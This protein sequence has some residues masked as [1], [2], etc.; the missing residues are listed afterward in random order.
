[1][2]RLSRIKSGF[3]LFGMCVM[4]QGPVAA[5]TGVQGVQ[6]KYQN[7]G[8][9]FSILVPEDWDAQMDSNGFE[10]FAE[11][12]EKIKPSDSNPVVADPNLTV[13]VSRNPMP[14]DQ[15]SLETYAAQMQ[16]G[17]VKSLGESAGLEVFLKKTVDLP[18]KRTGLLYY[19]R[20]KKGSF[21]V[22]NA[23]LVVS[24]D[25]HLFRVTLTDYEVGFDANLE[26]VFP[27]MASID[28]GPGK[29]E[30]ESLLEV[31][32]PWLAAGVAVFLLAAGL[33]MIRH[34][35][36]QEKLSGSLE[37]SIHEQKTSRVPFMKPVFFKSSQN[38]EDYDPEFR[39]TSNQS[40]YN[41]A[42]GDFSEVPLSA[43]IGSGSLTP[44]SGTGSVTDPETEVS[45]ISSRY[46][47]AEVSKAGISS[48]T[49]DVPGS[50]APPRSR[51]VQSQAQ[52]QEALVRKAPP[53]PPEVRQTSTAPKS[54]PRPP[55]PPP[56]A[57][58]QS[59]VPE[60][61]SRPADEPESKVRLS[62]R[63]KTSAVPPP[64][65]AEGS[66]A[67][68]SAVPKPSEAAASSA[69]KSSAFGMDF[70]SVSETD[71]SDDV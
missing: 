53:P 43:A 47:N 37:E 66:R 49:F 31:L 25:T 12:K 28:V 44:R 59:R 50:S 45:G 61:P 57:P 41:E 19:L 68:K 29:V 46:E 69:P 62:E 6:L 36:S 60:A 8:L 34:R 30:R 1:M 4:A 27:F 14:I 54:A 38:E 33:H 64:P 65:A 52:G 48:G 9:S 3:L 15:E 55:V 10:V 16:T 17:L 7:E 70:T 40:R 71:E 58:L 67:D 23:V 21:D 22:Y 42:D 56:Q 5:Q 20:Y 35:F 2:L 63:P 51:A 32:S 11:P 18:E 26:K 39:E 13:T 24:S